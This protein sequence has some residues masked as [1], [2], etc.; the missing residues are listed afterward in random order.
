MNK[1]YNS[2]FDTKLLNS[3][4]TPPQ[5]GRQKMSTIEGIYFLSDSS[6]LGDQLLT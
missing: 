6:E 4:K 5:E 2:E 3:N 1:K